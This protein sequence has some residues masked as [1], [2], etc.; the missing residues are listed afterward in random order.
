MSAGATAGHAAGVTLLHPESRAR[1]HWELSNRERALQETRVEQIEFPLPRRCVF[2]IDIGSQVFQL[3]QSR[4]PS[5]NARGREE[6]RKVAQQGWH[7]ERGQAQEDHALQQA[8]G[9]NL[10]LPRSDLHARAL[11]AVDVLCDAAKGL[12]EACDYKH[13]LGEE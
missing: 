9:I 6:V 2:R 1:D 3:F 7:T 5:R 8:L 10:C 13:D 12:V 11:P 4:V